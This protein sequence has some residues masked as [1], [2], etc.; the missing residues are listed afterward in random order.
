MWD[1]VLVYRLTRDR[2]ELQNIDALTTLVFSGLVTEVLQS[3]MLQEQ[4]CELRLTRALERN[5]RTR[6]E[7]ELAN[8]FRSLR[9]LQQLKDLE[10]L[11]FSGEAMPA[12]LEFLQEQD[13]LTSFQLSTPSGDSFVYAGLALALSNIP[14]LREVELSVAACTNMETLLHSSYSLQSLAIRDGNNQYISV[15]KL[16]TSIALALHNNRTLQYFNLEKSIGPTGVLAICDMLKVNTSLKKLDLSFT[17]GPSDIDPLLQAI[18]SAVKVNTTL[19]ELFISCESSTSPSNVGKD[20]ILDMLLHNYT[21]KHFRILE[22]DA[23]LDAQKDFYLKLN[24]IGRGKLLQRAED[25]SKQQWVDMLI[26]QKDDLDC[27]F[28]FLSANPSLCATTPPSIVHYSGIQY[29]QLDQKKYPAFETKKPRQFLQSKPSQTTTTGIQGLSDTLD[30]LQQQYENLDRRNCDL[31][32][33]NFK[34]KQQLDQA[35]NQMREAQEQ[36]T[37]LQQLA[38]RAIGMKESNKTSPDSNPCKRSRT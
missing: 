18:A 1:N 4:L 36:M 16:C 19:T 28:Y 5:D 14:T 20:D 15:D 12:L 9:G 3:S 23:E 11:H 21:L 32:R 30:H 31:N 33:R 17:C 29:L 24:R 27:L 25:G 6:T 13:T 26:Q 22:D 10:L 34:L 2:V 35:Q 7:P 8:L 37:V 38:N